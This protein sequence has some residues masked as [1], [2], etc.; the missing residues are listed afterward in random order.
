[1]HWF[2]FEVFLNSWGRYDNG[3]AVLLA[4]DKKKEEENRTSTTSENTGY[5]K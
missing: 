3:A 4:D 1:M 5:E 2:K